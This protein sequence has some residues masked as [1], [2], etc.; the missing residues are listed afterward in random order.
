MGIVFVLLFV[1]LSQSAW[2]SDACSTRA[3]VSSA[4]VSVSDGTRFVTDTFF[5][6]E[7]GLAIR[8]TEDSASQTIVVEGPLSWVRAGDKAGLGQAFHRSFALGHQYHALLLHFDEIVNDPRHTEEITFEGDS[9]SA[10]SGDLPYGGVVHRV[11]GRSSERPAGFVFEFREAEPI[12]VSLSDWRSYGD[13]QLPSMARIDD[14]ERV[15]EYRYTQ[16]RTEERSPFWFYDEIAA[17]EIDTVQVYRL[18]RKMLAAHCLG[19]AAMLADLSA[20]DIVSANRGELTH[21]TDDDLRERFGELF[22]RLDYLEYHDIAEPVIKVS[23]AGDLGW[24]AVNVRS[25]VTDKQSGN[26]FDDKWAWIMVVE[27]T[28]GAWRHVGNASNLAR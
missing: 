12:I 1:F 3:I 13:L 8:Q 5:H 21:S 24:I 22:E 23:E 2:S 28:D 14:G 25:V 16:V 26:G 11:E 7:D 10:S 20:D 9:H 17:P 27:K 18:H 19:D 4:E 6:S 15:F